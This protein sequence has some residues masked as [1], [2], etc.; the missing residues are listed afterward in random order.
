MHGTGL[1]SSRGAGRWAPFA[2]VIALGVAVQGWAA[3]QWQANFDS[4]E[5][6]VGLMARHIL[7]RGQVPVY[8]YGQR[9]MGSLDSMLAALSMRFLGPTV[10][11]LRV[12][13]LF[14]FAAFMALHGS[15]VTR[16]WGRRVALVSLL[17]LA[18]PG[19]R[20]LQ[21]TYHANI[22][23]NLVLGLGT[24]ALLLSIAAS[25][26]RRA[27]QRN[28]RTALLGATI[29]L[30]L[31]VNP[32]GIVFPCTI[33]LLSWLRA[34]QWATVH[35]QIQHYANRAG[36]W[37][38]SYGLVP[39]MAALGVLVFFSSAC[40]PSALFEVLRVAA[41]VQL[42][43][44][45]LGIIG[46]ILRVRR[47]R[48]TLLSG[49]AVF[50]GGFVLG[51]LMQWRA[52][53]L[54]GIA[55]SAAVSPSC[56][57]QAPA[58]AALVFGGLLPALWGIPTLRTIAQ[59]P[60][61]RIALWVLLSALVLAA[62]GDFIWRG[63]HA[64]RSFVTASPLSSAD[65][66]YCAVT[67]LFGLPLGLA[68]LGSNTAEI[69]HVRYLLVAWQ[70]GSVVVAL[71]LR[72]VVTRFRWLGGLALALWFSAAGIR[73]PVVLGKYWAQRAGNFAP[74]ATQALERYLTQHHVRGGYANFWVAYTLDFLL[75]ERVVITPYNYDRYPAY[76]EEVER[77][78]VQAYIFKRNHI[79]A[80]APTNLGT[81]VQAVSAKQGAGPGLPQIVE[82]LC[83]QQL[84]SRAHVANWDVWHVG[85]RSP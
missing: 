50:A 41:T 28:L 46:D 37:V 14:L 59:A 39:G 56:P 35:A 63:R 21:L 1:R 76:T 23:P 10:I 74:A 78:P 7:F 73:N 49:A 64:L 42:A 58:R 31:W 18:L 61:Y 19:W 48:A 2:V 11:A 53:L 12:P 15:L 38:L 68:V 52:W 72:R 43:A 4:D 69:A 13:Q 62:L 32:L 70:A 65:V 83:Q 33:A 71:F 81:L 51:D 40:Q 55:P 3:A 24:A 27:W 67:V 9:Y 80:D 82:R 77:L 44:I 75:E 8:F 34:P 30:G 5:A 16:W 60:P 6:I 20:I 25:P 36:R 26:P 22:S 54:H 84:L 85:A 29:G 66:P 79:P 45:A 57:A 17:V 47:G